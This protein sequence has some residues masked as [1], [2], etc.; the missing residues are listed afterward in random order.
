MNSPAFSGAERCRRHGFTLIELLVVIG[1]LAFLFGLAY[2]FLP[3]IYQRTEATKG[4][5]MVQTTLA[6]AR[7]RARRDNLACG[8]RFQPDTSLPGPPRFVTTLRW[9]QQ[10]PDITGRPDV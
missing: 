6:M 2:A 9:V 3:A 5:Q 8:I 1:I 7:Q 10:P 4:A